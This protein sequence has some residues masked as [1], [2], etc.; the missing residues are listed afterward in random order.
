MD[1][2]PCI[3]I[4]LICEV[5]DDARVALFNKLTKK[6]YF[7]GAEE[8][9]LLITADGTLTIRQIA[10]HSNLYSADQVDSLFL[11][12]HRLGFLSDEHKDKK[13]IVREGKLRFKLGV[14]NGNKIFK[15][16]SLLTKIL[17]SLIIHCSLLL[18][19]TGLLVFRHNFNPEWMEGIAVWENALV[20][21]PAIW[22]SISLHELGHAIIARSY[23]IPVPEIGILIFVFVP[24]VYTNLS[25][26][27]MLKRREKLHALFGGL[28]VNM[29]IAGCCFLCVPYTG[30]FSSFFLIC[31][32]ANITLLITNMIIFFKLDGYFILH[33]II[34]ERNLYYK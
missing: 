24:Y 21:L 11:T 8:Y 18:L 31:G 1:N 30:G 19:T 25:F 27:T 34:W 4:H 7:I 13:H 28:Y 15:A 32:L 22:I 9:K 10:E 29:A 6:S 14:F 17:S 33:E 23:H 16:D 12:F 5:L 3:S 2:K 20:L 26:I